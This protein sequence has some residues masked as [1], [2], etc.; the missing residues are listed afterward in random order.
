MTALESLNLWILRIVSLPTY[1]GSHINLKQL[2][3]AKNPNIISLL[4][5]TIVNLVN[6]KLLHLPHSKL[7]SLPH[8]IGNLVNL[9]YLYLSKCDNS[10]LP[11]CN[12]RI[13]NCPDLPTILTSSFCR[14]TMLRNSIMLL[15]GPI[16]ARSISLS[17]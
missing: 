6:M 17:T 8:S 5:S 15:L 2:D 11:S 16:E 3:L 13:N 1:V 10:S 12:I 4:N 9:K 7:V 14:Q